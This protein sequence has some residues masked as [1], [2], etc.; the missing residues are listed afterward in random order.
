MYGKDKT[1]AKATMW[2]VGKMGAAQRGRE[3]KAEN[4]IKNRKSKRF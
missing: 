1:V 2:K 4:T 3:L